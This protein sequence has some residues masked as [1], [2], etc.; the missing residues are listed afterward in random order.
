MCVLFFSIIFFHF[1]AKKKTA[2]IM[3]FE[4]YDTFCCVIRREGI[5]RISE[6]EQNQITIGKIAYSYESKTK[7]LFSC[8]K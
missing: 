6:A 8:E 4:V 5:R 3:E 2:L 7:T 1:L